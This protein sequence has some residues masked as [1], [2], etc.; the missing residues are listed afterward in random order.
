MVGVLDGHVCGGGSYEGEECYI[1][2]CD[3]EFVEAV[4]VAVVWFVGRINMRLAFSWGEEAG[5]K[6]FWVVCEWA[7]VM[8][9]PWGFVGEL[10]SR[11]RG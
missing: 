1:Y 11:W 6:A 10:E 9:R 5:D 3:I 2:I 4:G 7:L 8:A